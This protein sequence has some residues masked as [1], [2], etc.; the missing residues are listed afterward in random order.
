MVEPSSLKPKLPPRVFKLPLCAYNV[1][2]SPFD[3]TK[4]A[5]A[6]S[7]NYGLVGTGGVA[8][9]NV[10]HSDHCLTFL[11]PLERCNGHP[12]RQIIPDT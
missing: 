5:V 12:S 7:Q 3:G 11:L 9:V 1:Q 4:M 2:W 10:S 8:I 6:L